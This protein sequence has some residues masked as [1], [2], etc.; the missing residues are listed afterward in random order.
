M[1]S[2]EECLFVSLL[3]DNLATVQVFPPICSAEIKKL[4]PILF[5]PSSPSILIEKQR[6]DKTAAQSVDSLYPLP[7]G[8]RRTKA[9]FAIQ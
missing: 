5:G 6:G 2:A 8:E 9:S 3:R 4:G 1:M 7:Q